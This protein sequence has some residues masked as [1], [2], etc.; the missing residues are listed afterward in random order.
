MLPETRFI[1]NKY[2]YYFHLLDDNRYE[3]FST[4]VWDNSINNYFQILDTD[5]FTSFMFNIN[6]MCKVMVRKWLYYL[7]YRNLLI[8]KRFELGQKIFKKELKIVL[9]HKF[10][11]DIVLYILE[12]I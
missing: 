7:S 12:F 2:M 11:S 10:C 9:D 4:Y 5:K 3:L 6:Y 8:K 1:K